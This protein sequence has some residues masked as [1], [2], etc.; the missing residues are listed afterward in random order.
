MPSARR[1]SEGCQRGGME[2]SKKRDEKEKEER[3]RRRRRE[4]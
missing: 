1:G 4:G 2:G 3:R